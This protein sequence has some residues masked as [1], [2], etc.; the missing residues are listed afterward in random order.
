[1]EYNIAEAL[2]ISQTFLSLK[3]DTDNG[4]LD[5]AKRM[6]DEWETERIS[7]LSA[8]LSV[9]YDIRLPFVDACS[10]FRQA[11]QKCLS[12]GVGRQRSYRS[13]IH[14]KTYP[15]TARFV[16]HITTCIKT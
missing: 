2:E 1:M 7:I 13:D 4:G 5:G 3:D 14:N 16:F 15:I 12:W 8:V 9:G 10:G 11:A 6:L